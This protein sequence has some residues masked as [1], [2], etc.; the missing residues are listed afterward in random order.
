M[1]MI[2][3]LLGVQDLFSSDIS[4]IWNQLVDITF[5]IIVVTCK[6]DNFGAYLILD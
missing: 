1:G 6:M 4:T 2:G 3:G 5:E